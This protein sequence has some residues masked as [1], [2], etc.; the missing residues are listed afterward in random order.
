MST[1][2]IPISDASYAQLKKFAEEH[3]GLEVKP[4]VNSASLRGKIEAAAPGTETITVPDEPEKVPGPA[5]VAPTPAPTPA[6]EEADE[7]PIAEP[8]QASR[9]VEVPKCTIQISRRKDG[10]GYVQVG[11]NGVNYTI[12]EGV[13]IEVPYFVRDALE[14]AEQTDYEEHQEHPLSRPEMRPVTSPSYPYSLMKPADPIAVAEWEA[15]TAGQFAPG[16]RIEVP[17]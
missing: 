15:L 7:E 11:V 13:P 6:D 9:V 4:G 12:N 16:S 17:A 2:K 1:K 8:V 10:P 14:L 3:L 5:Q